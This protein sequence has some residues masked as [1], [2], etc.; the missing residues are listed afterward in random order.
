MPR[1]TRKPN[2]NRGSIQ[3][4]YEL[5]AKVKLLEEKLLKSEQKEMIA[6]ELYNKE[7]RLCSSARAN[8]TYYRNK[9]ISTTKEMIRITDKL[10]SATED[11]KL[12]KRCSDGRKT[13][14]KILEEQNKT[15]KYRKKMLKAQETLRMNQELNEQE[16]KP[17]RLCEVCDE[18][19]NHTANGT[20][21]VLKCGH[22]LCHSCLAQIATS[23]YIQ[24]PFDRLFTNIGVNELNDLPK[25]FVVLH[26]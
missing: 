24:C 10:N 14:K 15:M 6:T 7:K 1:R 5:E 23:H 4:K 21:R 22:T 25:N 2:Q 26:M 18:A 17:W 11:L 13:K 9:L 16:K 8:S 12:I 19:Y 3:R 20:P